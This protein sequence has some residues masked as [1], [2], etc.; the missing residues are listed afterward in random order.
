VIIEESSE[1]SSEGVILEYEQ[2]GQKQ[3]EQANA[4]SKPQGASKVIE[5]I[6]GGQGEGGIAK[7]GELKK[8][9]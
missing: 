1:S 8:I 2:N 4:E 7:R 6:I 5:F 9:D 3:P